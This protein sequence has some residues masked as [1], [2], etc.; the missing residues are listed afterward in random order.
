[1]LKHRMN[2]SVAYVGQR[3]GPCLVAICLCGL[4]MHYY[5]PIGF[6][7]AYVLGPFPVMLI[8]WYGYQV[9]SDKARTRQTNPQPNVEA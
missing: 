3:A 9:A 4:Y 7:N 1:M 8:A 5:G 2:M 6:G